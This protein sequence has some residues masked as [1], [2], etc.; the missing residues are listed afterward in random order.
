MRRIIYRVK[1]IRASGLIINV[2]PILR[3][4]KS[5]RKRS[6]F[7]EPFDLRTSIAIR[8]LFAGG[9][10]KFNQY[11]NDEYEDAERTDC[12]NV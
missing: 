6:I 9:F 7:G 4:L 10:G 3:N 2:I 12:G 5:Y 1:K 8:K 11:R